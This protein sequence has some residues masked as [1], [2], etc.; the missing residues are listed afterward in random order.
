MNLPI[1]ANNWDQVGGSESSWGHGGCSRWFLG[2]LEIHTWSQ[3][4]IRTQNNFSSWR[5][6]FLKNIVFENFENFEILKNSKI[7]REKKWK[8]WKFPMWILKIWKF[9]E[10][11]MFFENFH[12]FENIIFWKTVFLH[13]ERLFF[14]RIFFCDQVCI[15]STPR[16]YLEP[17]PCPHDDS[18]P[19]SRTQFSVKISQIPQI[20]LP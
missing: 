18:Q 7:S 16:N 14:V 3:K 9:P 13:D 6:T 12:V 19:P 11:L 17:P 20:Q 2:L 4:K 10:I 1:F 8:F 15:S 5:K